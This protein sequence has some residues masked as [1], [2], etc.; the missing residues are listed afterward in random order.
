MASPNP[1]S[2]SNLYTPPSDQNDST[3]A[4]KEEPKKLL[5]VVIQAI[6]LSASNNIISLVSA[7]NSFAQAAYD[8]DDP[9][10]KY[11]LGLFHLEGKLFEKQQWRAIDWFQ[12]AAA[13]GHPG[14]KKKL[15]EL[16]FDALGKPPAT[17]TRSGW[18][19]I[20]LVLFQQR[21]FVEAAQYFQK[22]ADRNDPDALCRMAFMFRHGFPGVPQQIPKAIKLYTLA[23]DLG[24]SEAQSNLGTLYAKGIGVPQDKE[25]AK[26][27]Y[28]KA[29]MQGEKVAQSNMGWHYF[30]RRFPDYHEAEKWFRLA[31]SNGDIESAYSLGRVFRDQKMYPEAIEWF[32]TATN[33]GW[34]DAEHDLGSLY[35][36]MDPPKYEEAAKLFEK[37]CKKNDPDAYHSLGVMYCE[38]W[39]FPCNIPKA[40]ELFTK[41]AKLGCK[42]AASALMKLEM[43]VQLMKQFGVYQG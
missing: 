1:R 42:H 7:A 10:A 32:T 11:R 30:D 23:A 29:A 34:T 25:R 38:G 9:E 26:E 4:N 43:K 2:G 18:F 3:D 40:K 5:P 19:D 27:L 13:Q 21:K 36:S 12:Q 41:S 28:Y 24:Q 17:S 8:H 6:K 39:H 20:G 15:G 33:A 16:N 37:A 14:A 31:Y 35:C 22:G